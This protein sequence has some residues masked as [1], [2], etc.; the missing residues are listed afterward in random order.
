VAAA[1]RPSQSGRFC[2]IYLWVT[3]SRDFAINRDAIHRGNHGSSGVR[4]R[5][6]RAYTYL[7][8]RSVGSVRLSSPVT[9]SDPA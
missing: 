2:P 8:V 5:F 4:E 9:T 7:V 3:I 1:F 6:G